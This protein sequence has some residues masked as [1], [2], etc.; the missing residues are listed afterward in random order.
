[1]EGLWFA[2]AFALPL[3]GG[4]PLGCGVG[5]VAPFGVVGLHGHLK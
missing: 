2:L 5:I 4:F 3:L 1:M